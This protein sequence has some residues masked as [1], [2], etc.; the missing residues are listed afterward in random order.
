[1]NKNI[2]VIHELQSNE[3]YRIDKTT[4]S[5]EKSFKNGEPLK[6]FKIDITGNDYKTRRIVLNLLYKATT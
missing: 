3:Y 5:V 1:M 6:S 2:S 4:G